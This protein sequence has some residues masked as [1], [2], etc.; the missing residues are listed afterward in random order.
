MG[1][2]WFQ[3]WIIVKEG[4]PWNVFADGLCERFGDRSMRDV[5]EEFNKLKQEG[6]VQAY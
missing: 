5:I 6:T 4:S 1:D 2:A 3:G